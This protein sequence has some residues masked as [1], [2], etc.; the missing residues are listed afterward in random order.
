MMNYYI[1]K[2][3]TLFGHMCMQALDP[4]PLLTTLGTVWIWCLSDDP[5]F[6]T[7]PMPQMN[8]MST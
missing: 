1:I 8:I 5:K 6:D 7:Y 4:D 2:C 3:P